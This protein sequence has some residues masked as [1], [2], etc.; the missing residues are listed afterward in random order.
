MKKQTRR[1][2]LGMLSLM[3]IS[4]VAFA[5]DFA[6]KLGG[7]NDPGPTGYDYEGEMMRRLDEG[8]MPEKYYDFLDRHEVSDTQALSTATFNKHR[9]RL[10]REFISDIHSPSLAASSVGQA[11]SFIPP[12]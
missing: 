9:S 7:G 12:E 1:K 11:L 8:T 5:S 2:I 4:S 3:P 6:N 10:T